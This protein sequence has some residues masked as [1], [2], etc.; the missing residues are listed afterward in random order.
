MSDNI[1][2]YTGD[3]IDAIDTGSA[4]QQR[5][6][7]HGYIAHDAVNTSN[8][9]IAAGGEARTTDRTAVSSGDVAG[10]CTDL[11]GK[12]VVL[13]YSIPDLFV[14]GQN[15]SAITDTT[16]TAVVAA[17]GSG[18]R[19][20]MTQMVL[21]M[22]T[23]V[24]ASMVKV[25]DGATEKFRVFLSSPSTVTLTFPV[26]YQFTANTALNVQA[27]TSSCSYWVSVSGF[28]AAN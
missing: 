7:V 14:R 22:D 26:P 24:T 12:Q 5:V 8:N 25:L 20:Y 21:T 19:F 15:A 4:K 11:F 23:G 28:K 2:A 10:F 18:I 27:V 16:S 17:I 3:I 9:P 6:R 1:T 13:P